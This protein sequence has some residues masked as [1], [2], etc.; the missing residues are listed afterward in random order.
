MHGMGTAPAAISVTAAR[1]SDWLTRGVVDMT[2]Q[3]TGLGGLAHG[4]LFC[5]MPVLSLNY[6]AYF[7]L[8]LDALRVPVRAADMVFLVLSAMLNFRELRFDLLCLPMLAIVT[9]AF[10]VVAFGHAQPHLLADEGV[11]EDA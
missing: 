4:L 3:A 9:L 5:G 10:W 1:L 6:L 2:R 11:L 7:A 8:G